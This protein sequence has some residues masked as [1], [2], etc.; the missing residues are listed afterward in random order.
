MGL[1]QQMLQQGEIAADDSSEQ[2]ELRL[3]GLVVKQ[4][5]KLKVYNRIYEAVFNQSWVK[6]Q[7]AKL[8]SYSEAITAWLKSNRQDESRLLGGK[9]LEDA[10][11]W[12]EDKSLSAEDYAFLTASQQKELE[13]E[14]QQRQIL[15][16]AK[17]KAEQLIR[18][19]KEGT[20]LEREGVIA[21]R[22]FEAGEEIEALLLA[23]QAGQ[24][25]QALI[26]D[27]RPLQ[28]YPATSPLLALQ[29]ILDNA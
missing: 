23:M 14:R 26:K 3:S 2:M 9:A 13:A 4:N 1:Y 16:E 8:R 22:R 27:G 29:V 21:L 19:A 6:Q 5:G 24:A 12:A 17:R 10:L 18:E 20:R 11:A 25:L 28:N 15:D 7:L